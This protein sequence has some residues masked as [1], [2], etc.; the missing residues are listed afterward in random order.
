[1]SNVTA[2]TTAQSGQAMLVTWQVANSGADTNS[3]P[4]T[5]SVYL[6][7]DPTFDPKTARYLGSVTHS[8]DVATNGGY[9][10][11]ASITIPVGMAGTFSV[12]V[13]TN[14]SNNL[15]TSST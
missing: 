6:S 10:Q 8:G 13:V 15:P 1:V 5:D 12:F 9:S 4:I 7:Q 2:P 3:I 11:S 14:N